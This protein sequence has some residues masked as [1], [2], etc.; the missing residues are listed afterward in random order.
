MARRSVPAYGC[1]V[2]I[3]PLPPRTH[4]ST[5][6]AA[7]SEAARALHKFRHIGRQGV[8]V[9]RHRSDHRVLAVLDWRA[10]RLRATQALGSLVETLGSVP[11]QLSEIDRSDPCIASASLVFADES[12]DRLCW[13]F[14]E[15][16]AREAGL[17]VWLDPAATY[18]LLCWPDFGEIGS[19]RHG[20]TLCTLLSERDLG[21]DDMVAALSLPIA[22]V[23]GLVNSMSLC[24]VLA[25]GGRRTAPRRSS[26]R[27]S[28]GTAE[29]HSLYARLC[30]RL[31]VR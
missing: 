8:A 2:P 28:I 6:A 20:A 18:R 1:K 23:C 10:R 16:L 4:A 22:L 27:R 17:A 31:G 12:L 3:H 26:L 11:T 30:K 29:Q 13:L 14:G 5:R 24:G 25:V 15:R 7:T 21:I 19:D 9:L